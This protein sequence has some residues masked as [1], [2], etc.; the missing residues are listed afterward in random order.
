MQLEPH[1]VKVHYD[2]SVLQPEALMWFIRSLRLLLWCAFPI[3]RFDCLDRVA[4]LGEFPFVLPSRVAP[5]CVLTTCRAS[6]GYSRHLDVSGPSS[7]VTAELEM[8]SVTVSVGEAKIPIV[9]LVLATIRH[10][11]GL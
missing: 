2:V 5:F 4:G 7:D 9:R 1:A 8:P 11:T 6:R 10:I 3:F